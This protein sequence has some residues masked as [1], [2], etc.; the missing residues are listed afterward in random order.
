MRGGLTL[1]RVTMADQTHIGASKAQNDLDIGEPACEPTPPE[2]TPQDRPHANLLPVPQT[3]SRPMAVDKAI[4][5]TRLTA[6]YVGDVPQISHERSDEAG[7]LEASYDLTNFPDGDA[8]KAVLRSAGMEDLDDPLV[9]N[10]YPQ[11]D[12][13]AFVW[14]GSDLM[15]LTTSNPLTGEMGGDHADKD[16]G[17]AGRIALSGE[18]SAV[19]A[20]VE[21]ID[22]NLDFH[23]GSTVGSRGFI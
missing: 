15:I 9:V 1:K 20:A 14:T 16:E 21:A 4:N 6:T 11:G 12:K 19:M 8:W 22:N 7:G 10:L 3:I 23:K 18:E 13:Y 17:Y 5:E 2:T